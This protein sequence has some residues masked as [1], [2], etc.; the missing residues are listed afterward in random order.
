M[1]QASGITKRTL[2][3]IGFLPDYSL[4]VQ[5]GLIFFKTSSAAAK[6]AGFLPFSRILTANSGEAPARILVSAGAP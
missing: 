3:R 1:L 4:N 2:L 5:S 6:F